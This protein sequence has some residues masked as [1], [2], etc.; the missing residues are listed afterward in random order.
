M[1]S[2]FIKKNAG[3]LQALAGEQRKYSCRRAARREVGEV[4]RAARSRQDDAVHGGRGK[5][6]GAQEAGR[7]GSQAARDAFYKG[8]I[9]RTVTKFIE[10]EGGPMRFEDFAEFRVKFEPTVRTR[11]DDIDLHA[12][13]PWSQGPVLPMAL[14]ILKG[15][16]L[17]AMGHNSPEYIHV[18]TEALKLA[19]ADRHHHFGDP[20][21]IKV[22]MKGL[23]SDR[24]AAAPPLDDQPGKGV[25]GNAARGRS[26]DAGRY[27]AALRAGARVRRSAGAG[28][29][30]VPVRDRQARQRHLV[31]AE[32]RLGQDADHSRRGD[33]VLGARH[34]IVVR[35]GASVARSRRASGRG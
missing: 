20:R 21:F 28:R 16:D 9:A 31:H 22:P 11:F 34:A 35:S 14:N 33:P 25:A 4:F 15:F 13:G 7:P 12:C 18:V 19:F 17:K 23:M 27:P 2:E 1:M 5:K 3:K 8:D 32:R 24:Y 30:L 29:H 10:K 26:R 6:G